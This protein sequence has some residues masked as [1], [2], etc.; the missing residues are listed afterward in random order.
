MQSFFSTTLLFL[1]TLIGYSI[2][3]AAVLGEPNA[4]ESG[5]QSRSDLVFYGGFEAFGACDA[6]FNTAWGAAWNNRCSEVSVLTGS[7]AYIGN[8]TW[9]VNYPA[10]G[11]GPASTGLQIPASFQK[12]AAGQPYDSLY[13]RYYV[14]FES[15][16]DFARGGK[17]PGLMSGDDAWSRSGGNQPNG[18]NG[19]TMRFMWRSGG[20]AVV[21]A[22][23]PPGKYFGDGWGYDMALNRNFQTG[24]WHCIEQFVKINTIG[25]QNGKCTVWLDDEKVLDLSDIEYR[26]V[27]NTAGKVGGIYISTFHGGNDASWAPSVTSY[28][29]F[30]A[31][32]LA[33]KRV[34]P[35]NPSS[36]T[37]TGSMA[38]ARMA[39]N[40]KSVV[41]A[42]DIHGRATDRRAVS[43][44]VRVVIWSNAGRSTCRLEARAK[45]L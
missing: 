23:L 15:G 16:F 2:A 30:D 21:Y 20:A 43:E 24:K 5:L 28:T 9:R 11:V 3:G 22:Y 26:T 34:G 8:K 25:Q 10:R 36:E 4:I 14:K 19:W 37:A 33:T 18:T 1:F 44:G 12:M 40:K 17:L 41:R 31:F 7:S 6:A 39:P 42:F 35:Y 27:D 38:A 45:A 29:Q 32:A 13:L